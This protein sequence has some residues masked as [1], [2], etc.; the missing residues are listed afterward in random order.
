MNSA[1]FKR[2]DHLSGHLYLTYMFIILGFQEIYHFLFLVGIMKTIKVKGKVIK[3]E[4]IF[5]IEVI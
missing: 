4:W 1:R 2:Q 5:I 3:K